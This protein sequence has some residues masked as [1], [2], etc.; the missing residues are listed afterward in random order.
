MS[1]QVLARKWRPKDFSELIGQQHVVTVLTN[2]L[3]QQRLHHAYLFTGTR[4]VGKTTI[5][6]IFAKSLNCQQGVTATPCGQCDVC[7]DIDAGR[8][9]DLL[10]VD[11]ASRTKVDDTREILDN[12][13]YAPTRGRYKVYLIDE[14]HMLSKSSFNALLK[15]LEEP[16][17]HVKFILA[18][19]DPQKLPITV[20][21]RCL[22]FHLKALTQQ[23]ITEKLSQILDAE[24]VTYDDASIALLSKA[25]RGSMRDCLSLT[26]QAIAQG[27]G[28]IVS[29]NVLQMLGGVDQNWV[30]KILIA[31]IKQ[32]PQELLNLS[33]HIASYAPSYH[34]LL[35]QL[36]QLLHQVA[37]YQLVPNGVDLDEQKRQLID[38]FAKSMAPEDVQLYY[39]IVVNGRKD[40]AYAG[41][42]QAG[43]DMILL[44]M[45]AFKPASIADTIS[46]PQNTPLSAVTNVSDS[47]SAIAHVAVTP[48]TTTSKQSTP[49]DTKG[50][51]TTQIPQQAPDVSQPST[52]V[53]AEAVESELPDVASSNQASNTPS[54]ANV[55]IDRNQATDE[56]ALMAEQEQ[57]EAMASVQKQQ[58]SSQANVASEQSQQ[59]LQESPQAESSAGEGGLSPE[60]AKMVATRNLL[61]SKK[62]AAEGS[63]KKSLT[64]TAKAI[65]PQEPQPASSTA[66]T[67]E[68][69]AAQTD[70]DKTA[71]ADLPLTEREANSQ[72]SQ[73]ELSADNKLLVEQNMSHVP[74][75]TPPSEQTTVDDKTPTHQAPNRNNQQ[76]VYQQPVLKHSS[77][78]NA[79]DIDPTL[80]RDA[81]QVDTWAHM[82]D[83][84]SLTGRV[85]QLALNSLLDSQSTDEHLIIHVDNQWAHLNSKAAY[86]AI[87]DS[88]SQ[89][90]QRPCQVTI[91]GIEQPQFTP[92]AIQHII[93]DIRL[94]WAKQVI[95]S[96][97]L[98]RTLQQE[99]AAFVDENSVVPL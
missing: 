62:K 32:D 47:E 67:Y 48:R 87:V 18:T 38:K 31:L 6:R 59:P 51:D 73:P 15:T 97:E 63:V 55:F 24:S 27:Q 93:N 71:S 74:S 3:S 33:Q 10:E 35:A 81:N 69:N 49:Q 2:A 40:I 37:L 21:S 43:F 52:D 95:A 45:L 19:T 41:D 16:P 50:Q 99:F 54:K 56:R 75:N 65:E 14:V 82:I 7:Q 89:L 94:N 86:Q 68:A 92:L 57:L 96:D 34:N 90:K 78:F 61:R 20:L 5:A 44:R 46:V 64:P 60:L 13:Q 25:A 98:V 91:N 22:Q 66:P 84:M 72:T 80:I 17:E 12:V 53:Q 39:Q 11:A 42:E 1:Y 23:Q 76:A 26:D 9:V 70:G 88:Y 85:R 77:E 28:H 29:D 8:F 83:A 4:G 79:N 36:V 58:A 30:Y